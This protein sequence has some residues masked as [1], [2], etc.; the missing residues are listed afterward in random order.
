MKASDKAAWLDAL[1]SGRYAQG[2]NALRDKDNRFCC[3]G[4]LCDVMSP[5]SWDWAA[6]AWW[7]YGHTATLPASL[8]L[9]TDLGMTGDRDIQGQ[10]MN[11]N[12][13]GKS[14]SEIADWIEANVPA[15]AA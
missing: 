13:N 12:D 6:D 10:L 3:L 15:D 1:R 2:Q 8:A 14:F 11:M 9:K 5:S 4:V 7:S